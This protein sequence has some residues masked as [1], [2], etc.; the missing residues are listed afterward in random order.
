MSAP[1]WRFS[2]GRATFTMV[3]STTTKK[4]DKHRTGRMNQRRGWEVSIT[5]IG[6]TLSYR[7]LFHCYSTA[8]YSTLDPMPETRRTRTP[9]AGMEAALLAS[10]AELLE[11]EGPDGLSVRRIA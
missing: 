1:R 8:F 3:L 11:Q 7:T 10:A 5:G 4:T 6:D 2:V 9:S